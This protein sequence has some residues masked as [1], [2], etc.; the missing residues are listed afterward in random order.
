M[1]QNFKLL[2]NTTLCQ[3]AEI[4]QDQRTLGR[5]QIANASKNGGKKFY[6]HASNSCYKAYVLKKTLKAI[7]EARNKHEQHDESEMNEIEPNP[8]AS[9]SRITRS[10][11]SSERAQPCTVFVFK[12]PFNILIQSTV[13]IQ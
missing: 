7:E 6:Y 13:F 3:A 11:E 12:V 8:E 9:S 10:Q 5:I 4:R 1:N 2:S